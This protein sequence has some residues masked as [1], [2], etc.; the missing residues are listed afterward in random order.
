M[1]REPLKPGDFIEIRNRENGAVFVGVVTRA[2]AKAVTARWERVDR[3]AD[4]VTRP[5]VLSD[6]FE[7]LGRVVSGPRLASLA[8][9][10]ADEEDGGT[11]FQPVHQTSRAR[12]EVI[13]GG[14]A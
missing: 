11:G 7:V 14:A 13:H 3:N 10:L 5:A 8:K 6:R 1:T 12:Q 9:L 2:T 4:G